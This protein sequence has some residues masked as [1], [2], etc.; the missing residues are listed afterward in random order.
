MAIEI[1]KYKV[2]KKEGSFELR[3]YND[4]I[5]AKVEVNAKNYDEAANTGFKLLADFI[6]G[7]NTKRAKISMTAPV[8]EEE[9]SS[10]KIAM[11]APVK[12]EAVTEHTYVISFTMPK[13]YSLEN[14]PVPNNK[15]VTFEKI[16]S[17]KVAVLRFSGFVNERILK[18]KTNEL[19]T[20]I[21]EQKINPQGNF[22]SAR[23]DPPWTL[24]FLRRNEVIVSVG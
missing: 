9:I 21:T 3:E 10:E 7:N 23:Y 8:G 16:P 24:W 17:H 11:T 4:F 22:S 6:F 13:R 12:V 20:W 19:Q 15:A 5:I 18:K 14:L 1:P 2:I